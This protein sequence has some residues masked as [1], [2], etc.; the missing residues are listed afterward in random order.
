MPRYAATSLPSCGAAGGRR[1]ASRGRTVSG[2]GGL[3]SDVWPQGGGREGVSAR[4]VPEGS[5]KL[6]AKS[7]RPQQSCPT[8]CVVAAGSTGYHGGGSG[9]PPHTCTTAGAPVYMPGG[10]HA[11]RQTSITQ[12]RACE[13]W[14]LMRRRIAPARLGEEVHDEGEEEPVVVPADARVEP[15]AVVVEGAD[16]LVA[17][18]AVLAGGAHLGAGGTCPWGSECVRMSGS[19]VGSWQEGVW[20]GGTGR[21]GRLGRWSACRALA[22]GAVHDVVGDGVVVFVLERG[23]KGR[24]KRG[25][26]EPRAP[27]LR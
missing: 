11:R 10:R 9:R 23:G 4:A 14:R 24:R 3:G 5:V 17:H 18:A 20:R 8:S 13:A 2:D 15:L 22:V 16:A 6:C 12:A 7:Q 26:G 1:R 19:R 21:G 27:I 25:V